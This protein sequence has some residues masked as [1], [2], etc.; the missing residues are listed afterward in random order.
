[1]EEE[2]LFFGSDAGYDEKNDS[3]KNAVFII[4]N[5]EELQENAD[6][7]SK[8]LTD[9]FD[10]L[11]K[12]LPEPSDEEIESGIAGILEKTHPEAVESEP[13]KTNK[14]KK[15]TLRVLLVAAIL[16]ALSFT[17]IFA[18]GS[19]HNIAI[20]KGFATFAKDAV[21]VVFFDEADEAEEDYIDIKTL[22][23]DL[24]VNG[25]ENIVIPEAFYN[26][27]SSK[28][29]YFELLEDSGAYRYVTFE[30]NNGISSF[31]FKIDCG[32]FDEN[33]SFYFADLGSAETVEVNG[34]IVYIFEYD[35]G[36]TAAY[37]TI[38]KYNYSLAA[39][40]SSAEMIDIAQSIVVEE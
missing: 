29:Q 15:V 4:K 10:S 38:G 31:N 24:R 36:D 23:E 26:Y 16:S 17:C 34:L 25:Y 30:L 2:N 35:V 1:M 3:E 11:S 20:D 22:L 19:R 8:G 33:A 32:N 9:F 14:S 37:F 28:P 6:I 18:V 12:E 21:K 5:K 7:S 27:K 40:I 13:A 39:K